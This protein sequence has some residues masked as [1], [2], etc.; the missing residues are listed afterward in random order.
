MVSQVKKL[1]EKDIKKLR[2]FEKKLGCCVVALEPQPRPA[3]LNEA[4]LKDL[5]SLESDMG[6]ILIAYKC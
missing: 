3:N 1:E 2:D 5:K 6:V 4:Q